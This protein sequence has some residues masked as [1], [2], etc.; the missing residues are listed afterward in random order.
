L[1]SVTE[2]DDEVIV[3]EEDEG[4]ELIVEESPGYDAG[5]N[6]LEI[7]ELEIVEL[8]EYASGC[9]WLEVTESKDLVDRV[10]PGIS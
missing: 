6:S 7:V 10:T 8:P 4:I 9:D 1:I 5:G 2:D 3:D